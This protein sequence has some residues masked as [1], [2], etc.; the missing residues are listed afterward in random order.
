MLIFLK[1]LRLKIGVALF[2]FG[3]GD[4]I[5]CP[6]MHAHQPSRNRFQFSAGAATR[7]RTLL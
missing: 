2:N 6:D 7:P 3:G 4:V 1:L 5:E